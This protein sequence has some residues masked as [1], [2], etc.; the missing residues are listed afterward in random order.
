MA[1]ILVVD[2]E[3]DLQVLIKQLQLHHGKLQHYFREELIRKS[4]LLETETKIREQEM[5][6]RDLQNLFD[7]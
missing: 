5:N 4:D 1:K 6:L 2:D 3:V 7:R